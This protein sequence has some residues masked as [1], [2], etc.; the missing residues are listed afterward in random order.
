MALPTGWPEAASTFPEGFTGVDPNTLD[1][2]PERP[3]GCPAEAAAKLPPESSP[4]RLPESQRRRN[5]EADGR[6]TGKGPK[7]QKQNQTPKT[8]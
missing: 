1:A 8:I 3:L 2:G 5:T 6:S 4:I 7:Q